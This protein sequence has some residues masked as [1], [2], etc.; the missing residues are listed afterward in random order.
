M[1]SC[2]PAWGGVAY[3]DLVV[4]VCEAGAFGTVGASSMNAGKLKAELSAITAGTDQPFGVNALT[5]V[6]EDVRTFLPLII[7][8][9]TAVY[10]AALGVP[11]EVVAELQA[12]GVKVASL[13]GKTKHAERAVE[14]GVDFVIATG[15]EGGGHTGTIATSTL[16][17]SIVDAVG[18]QVPVVA[19]GGIADGRGLAAAL[20]LGADGVWVGTRFAA[21]VE[22]RRLKGFHEAILGAKDDSTVITRAYSGKTMRVIRSA[23]TDHFEKHPEELLPFPAQRMLAI[24]AKVSNL[25]RSSDADVDP[26]REAYL[27]GQVLATSR[28]SFLRPRSCGRS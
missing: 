7:D 14:A 16:I 9:G 18:S 22:A 24:K 11:V 2:W 19:G 28:L 21:S 10:V 1:R 12:N 5:A 3:S 6:P 23:W 8:A 20:A 13:C 17:P 25:G 15:T 4:A 26:E 27:A